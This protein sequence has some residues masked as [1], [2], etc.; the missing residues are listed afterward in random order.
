M[1]V[2]SPGPFCFL[3]AR[4]LLGSRP[5]TALSISALVALAMLGI[6]AFAE[7]ESRIE[8]TYVPRSSKAFEGFEEMAEIFRTARES[9]GGI[10]NKYNSDSVVRVTWCHE[11]RPTRARPRPP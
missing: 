1:Y 7:W 9:R 5:K 6:I 3:S 11:I 10:P 2:R 8:Y 4:R